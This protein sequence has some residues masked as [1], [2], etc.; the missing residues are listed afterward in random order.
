MGNS[1]SAQNPTTTNPTTNMS[2]TTDNV[3]E[4]TKK[5]QHSGSW[6]GVYWRGDPRTGAPAPSNA[7]W[8]R[9]GAVLKGTGPYFVKG[10]NWMK[11]TQVQQAGASGFV[12]V[13]D[14]TFMMYEQGGPLLRDM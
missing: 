7:N 6:T 2:T 14:G 13:P 12:A 11:V 8:P 4:I 3:K 10:G 5:L 9:N 1:D